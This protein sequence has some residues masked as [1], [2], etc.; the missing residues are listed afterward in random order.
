MHRN[1]LPA[2]DV[3][4]FGVGMHSYTTTLL[5]C[6]ILSR[7]DTRPALLYCTLPLLYVTSPYQHLTV[8]RLPCLAR[9]GPRSAFACRYKAAHHPR[10]TRLQCTVLY[11][12]CSMGYVA[13][14]TQRWT[15]PCYAT[16][17]LLP[18]NDMACTSDTIFSITLYCRYAAGLYLTLPIRYKASLY[19]ADT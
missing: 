6:T 16:P 14:P 11:P 2:L 12:H 15:M 8:I 17:V 19:S 13:Q 7:Y 1:A 18:N 4:T 9:T 5:R 10:L 3:T